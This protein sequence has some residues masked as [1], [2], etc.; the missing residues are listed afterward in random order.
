MSFVDLEGM[1]KCEAPGVELAT[2]RN[3]TAP[4]GRAEERRPT[5]LAREFTIRS[6][7]R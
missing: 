2:F 1:E 3:A 6:H 7:Y 4:S 5:C